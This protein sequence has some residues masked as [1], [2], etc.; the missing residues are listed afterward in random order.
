MARYTRIFRVFVSSTFSDLKAEREALQNHVFPKL[1][2][3]CFQHNCRFQA[4][5]LRWGVSEEAALD[6]QT[7]NICLEELRRCQLMTPRPNFIILLG[8]RYGWRPLPSQIP[9]AEFQ[10]LERQI[11]GE[12]DRRFLARWY[13]RDDNLV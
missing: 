10:K 3:L 13:E 4:I 7:M 6:Q 1:R 8:E 12:K 2:D 11:T 9:A 5:D